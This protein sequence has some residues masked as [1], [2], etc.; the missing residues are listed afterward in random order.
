[1]SKGAAGVEL[2]VNGGPKVRT[3]PFPARGLFGEEERAA[4]VALF[5]RSIETGNAFGYDGPEEEAYCREFAE[6]LGGGFADAVNSGTSAVYV[7]LRALDLEPFTE[8]IC[9]PVTDPGGIMPVALLNCIPVVADSHPASYNAGPEQIEACLSPRTSAILV[10]HVAGEPADMDPILE[11]ARA[12]NL[13]VI[14]DCAQSHGARYR[15]KLVG[16]LGTIA[17]FSTMSGKHHATGA[18]GGVVFTRNESLYWAARRA[19]DRG[20]PFGPGGR[21]AAVAPSSVAGAAS[22]VIA[23]LN[24]NLNDLAAAIGRVQLKKL[25]GIVAGRRRVAAAVADGL[26]ERSKVVSA[27]WQP[28]GAEASYWFMRLHVEASRLSVDATTFAR[29][30]AAEGIPVNPRYGSIHAHAPWMAE[31]RV[32]GTSGYPWRAPEYRAAG[33]DPDRRYTCPNAVT[34][35]E[36]DFNLSIHESWAEH[37]VEDTLAAIEKVERAYLKD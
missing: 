30:V 24:L 22:N 3:G 4:A 9:P 13:P 33:G 17:A 5:D 20:K 14:E 2:A 6:Y 1:M 18:Q 8:V 21:G 25:D 31:R 10:A 7:A 28:E 11:I 35:V 27:G 37:E 16:T 12:R 34:V 19:S 29:A 23:S 36:S 26:R 15:G 32:F